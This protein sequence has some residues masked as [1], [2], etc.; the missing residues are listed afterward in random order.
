MTLLTVTLSNET[1]HKMTRGGKFSTIY[2]AVFGW[3]FWFVDYFVFL[4]SNGC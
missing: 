3:L 2:V 4:G 1:N